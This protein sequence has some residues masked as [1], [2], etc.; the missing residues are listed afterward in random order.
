MSMKEY[1][2]R[3]NLSVKQFAAELAISTSYLYQLI[4]GER[5]P[6]LELAQGIEK[7]TS[8]EVTVSKLMGLGKNGGPRPVEERLITLEE[9]KDLLEEKI[10]VLEKQLSELEC[11]EGE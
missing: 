7:C 6:S 9:A 8:G 5:K 11:L 2:F 10:S 4:R 1:L 3:K